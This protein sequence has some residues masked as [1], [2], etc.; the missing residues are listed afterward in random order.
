MS[1]VVQ[2]GHTDIYTINI[3]NGNTM[4]IVEILKESIKIYSAR[5]MICPSCD[6]SG[7]DRFNT[8]KDCQD[9]SGVGSFAEPVQNSINDDATM[10][11][12]ENYADVL[13]NLLGLM[14]IDTMNKGGYITQKDFGNIRQRITKLKNSN[15]GQYE[16]SPEE[17]PEE[18]TITTNKETG[19]P[20][21]QFTPAKVI[22]P[23]ITKEKIEGM[24]D[25]FEQI[26]MHAQKNNLVIFM[27]D[28]ERPF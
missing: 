16:R 27:D 14:K 23:K 26:V 7:K 1:V 21:I 12:D 11:I 18:R 3:I 22:S 9:C 5:P 19:L 24:L 13:Y 4:K 20:T 28:S 15:L 2:V 8:K 6:G 17:E 10:L 25:K